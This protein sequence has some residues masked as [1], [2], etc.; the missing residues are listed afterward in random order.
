V[1]PLRRPTVKEGLNTQA[2]AHAR[3]TDTSHN[4]P[5][6]LTV[7]DIKLRKADQSKSQQ[8]LS[9]AA[10]KNEGTGFNFRY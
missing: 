5:F 3:A 6:V 7:T 1:S 9:K 8:N 10:Q 4:F 2:L